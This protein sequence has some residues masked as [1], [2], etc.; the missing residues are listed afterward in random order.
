M[1]KPS[2]VYQHFVEHYP[3]QLGQHSFQGLMIVIAM[4]FILLS[5]LSVVLTMVV[6]ESSW[7]L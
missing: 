7:W 3:N 5:S 2:S 6:W 1:E 4:G